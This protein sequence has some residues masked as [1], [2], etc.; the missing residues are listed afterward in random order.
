MLPS[1]ISNLRDAGAVV[2]RAEPGA[3]KTTRVPP[4]ILDAGLADMQTGERGQ[5]VVLQ[6]RRAAARST[7]ARIAFE[8]GSALGGEIG[9]QVRGDARKAKETRILICTDGVFLR[10]LQRDP[11]LEGVG[12]VIFDEFHERRIDSDLALALVSQVKTDVR[13]DLRLVVMSA[14]LNS[15]PITK[16]LNNC[17][18]VESPG[19][20]YPVEMQYFQPSPEASLAENTAI[21]ILEMVRKTD[22]DILAFLPGVGEIRQAEDSLYNKDIQ[23]LI[24]SSW[25]IMPLYGDMPLDDQ[26]K[27]L[28]PSNQRK[29]VLATN[30][31][32]TSLTIDGITAVVD[33]GRARISCLDPALGLNRLELT[34][35][36][37]ASAAQRAGRAGRTSP[38]RCLRLWSE[39]EHHGL[40]DFEEPEIRRVELSQAVLQLFAWGEQDVRNF[41]WYEAPSTASLDRA[42]ELLDLLGALENGKLTQLGKQMS[43]LPVQP[44]LARLFIDGESAGFAKRAALAAVLL[45]ERSPFL[46]RKR[47]AVTHVTDSDLLDQIMAIESYKAEGVRESNAGI[48]SASAAKQLDQLARQLVRE[49]ADNIDADNIHNESK[50][51]ESTSAQGSAG[52]TTADKTTAGKGTADKNTADR[53]VLHSISVGF[54][55]RVCKMRKS[56]GRRGVMVGGRGVR[57]SDES[58]L[59]DCDLFVAVEMHDSGAK[60]SLVRRAS[61]IERAWL[62]AHKLTVSTEVEYD[63]DKRRAVA[64]KRVRYLDLIIEEVSIPVTPDIECGAILAE[65]IKAHLDVDSLIDD[66]AKRYLARIESLRSW[67]PELE[68]P[69]FGETIWQDLL[70]EWCMGQT[71]VDSLSASQLIAL[72]QS[73][74][75]F[76]QLRDLEQEA[77]DKIKLPSG[78]LHKLQYE[79]G[80]PPV[81]AVR[82]QE[83]F[84]LTETPKIARSRVP[85]LLHLLAPNFRVQQITADLA[86]FWKNTYPSLRKELKHRYPKHAW[87]EN[88]LA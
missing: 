13:S 21:G 79:A 74:L 68:L 29:I 49:S 83:L 11:L 88:P 77:P 66:E 32:E 78:R 46:R 60:E 47:D 12:V 39:R 58:A 75:T 81:L 87:P 2:L 42:L 22:G 62:P 26:L 64:L 34:R 9:Y 55:D 3:G 20:N 43:H 1:I 18:A 35:I 72:I 86:A 82:M 37:K 73:R 15:D 40:A 61:A 6:P 51:N 19:R 57:L 30:V 85:V 65:G 38:G 71:S 63:Q 67:L 56:G 48:L 10:R 76:E 69:E 28:E 4:A 25:S 52:K 31:A 16:Y 5:I 17:P 59:H 50:S 41:A 33:S 84:G 24:Q 14:T 45:S 8:R 53:A 44:R 80:K 36:S 70:P 23:N 7:A 54:P 27:V